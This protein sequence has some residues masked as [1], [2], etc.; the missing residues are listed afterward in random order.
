M[1]ACERFE[2]LA[3]ESRQ[4]KDRT[5]RWRQIV[6]AFLECYPTIANEIRENPDR[7]KDRADWVV[8]TA[9]GYGFE[10]TDAQFAPLVSE[11]AKQMRALGKENPSSE[12]SKEEVQTKAD[13]VMMFNGQFVHDAQ[14]LRI[15]GAGIDFVF[16]RTYKNQVPYNGPLG[17]NWD[18]N[19]NLWLRVSNQT[20][21]RSTGDLREEAYVRHPKFDQGGFD[22]WVPPDGQHA[23]IIE[24]GDSFIW[25]TPSGDRHFYEPDPARSSFLHRISLIEDKH[26]NFLD[27]SY[28]DDKLHQVAINHVDR[29]V[30]FR[31]DEQN[32]INLIIDYTGRQWCYFYDFFEDLI[33]VTTPGT[34]RYSE[35]V[36]VCYEYSS[37]QFAGELQHN[38]TH[39]ID[40][41]GQ[42]HLE[43][44]YGTEP[45]R[46]RFNRVISQRQGGGEFLFEYEDIIQEFEIDYSEAER[47]AHQTIMVERSGHP[48]CHVYNKF[49]NLLSKEEYIRQDG[50]LRTLVW[51]YRHNRDGK[52]IATLSPEG[53]I[54]QHLYGREYF[55]RSNGITDEDEVSTHDALTLEGRQGFGQLLAT[56]RRGRYYGLAELNLA[57]DVWGDIFPDI[58]GGFESDDTVIKFTYKLTYGQLLTVSNPRFTKSADP[59][60]Q[61]ELAG[62]HPRY[63]ES[64]TQYKYTG[65]V[66]DPSRL[67]AEIQRP[68]P[69]LPDGTLADSVIEK[70]D[71]YDDRGRLLRYFDSAGVLTEHTYF[72]SGDGRRE[73]YLRRTVL[74]AG[75]L[76]NTTEY[77]VDELG[78]VMAVHLPRSVGAPPGH[79]VTRTEYNEIDQV[80]RMTASPPFNFETRRFYDKNG[81]LEREER[82]A[83][84]DTGADIPGAP[85]VQTFEYDEELNLVRETIGG[86]DLSDHLVT[87]HCYDS[88]GQRVL[89]VLP[90]GNRIGFS[91]DERLLPVAQTVAVGTADAATRHV[92][93]DGD[94][95]VRRTR[96]ARNDLTTLTLDPFG[97]VT[98]QED[99]L[100][101]LVRRTYD[102]ASN[103]T[104][105]RI[106]ERQENGTFVLVARSEFEYDELG[107][108]IRAGVNRFEDALL[109]TNLDSD[110]L[111]SPGLGELLVTQTF[112]DAKGRVIRTVDPLGRERLF[113]YDALDRVTA[114][115]DA[116]GNRIENQYDAHGNLVRQDFRDVVRNPETGGIVSERIFSSSSTYDELDR[117]VTDTNTLGNVIHYT[118]DSRNNLVCRVDPLGNVVRTQFDIYGRLVT[119][120]SDQTD[121]GLEEG[122]PLAS[123]FTRYKYDANG[124]L[125]GITD[126]L[127]RRIRQIYDALD[128]RRAVIFP[129]GSRVAFDYDPD[130]NL[131]M[132][133][134]NNG[135]RRHYTVDALGRTTRV[136]VDDVQLDAAI[137]AE[138]ANF[139]A[140]GYDAL[141]RRVHEENNYAQIDIRFNSLG[142]PLQETLTF[143]TSDAHLDDPRIITRAFNNAGAL[144]ELTYPNG[145]RLRFHRDDLDR[146][147]RVE[148]MVKGMD[149][150]GNTATSDVHDIAV[151]EYA[152]R[153]RSRCAF[154]NGGAV[155][156]RHDG[157]G[158]IIEIAHTSSDTLLLTIQYLFDAVGNPRF[159]NEIRP[160]ERAGEA[161]KYDSFYRLVRVE[162]RNDLPEFDAD[163]FAPAS[164]VSHPIPDRQTDINALIGPLALIPGTETLVYDLV[165]NRK[166]EQLPGGG[167][168]TYAINDQDQYTERNE[169]SFTYDRNGNLI[170]DAVRKYRYDSLNRL[171]RVE[172]GG[173]IV[174]FFHDSNGRRILEL[175]NGLATH[176]IYD[177]ENLLAEYRNGVPFAQYVHDDDVDRPLQIAAKAGDPSGD[178]NEHWYHTDLVG[179][180]RLL[181]NRTGA[182]AATYRYD[183]F[184]N[185]I[186]APTEGPYNPMRYTA[187][188]F[189]EDLSTYDY[190]ARQYNPQLGRFHQRDSVGMTDGTNLY[191]YTTNN[192]MAFSDPLGLNR[193]DLE[194]GG[195]QGCEERKPEEEKKERRLEDFTVLTPQEL[196]ALYDN[197]NDFNKQI[198]DI[199]EWKRGLNSV[200][201]EV[202]KS[203]KE[204]EKIL[205]RLENPV[206]P[207]WDSL[208]NFSSGIGGVAGCYF[209]GPY[210]C[211]VSLGVAA[212]SIYY[213]EEGAAAGVVIDCPGGV[214]PCVV[215]VVTGGVSVVFAQQ[216]RITE[217]TKRSKADVAKFLITQ[218]KQ[219]QKQSNQK[220]K[221]LD[222][223]LDELQRAKSEIEKSINAH[224][225]FER[226]KK[227]KESPDWPW[228]WPKKSGT[229]TWL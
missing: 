197:L 60:Q 164:V 133:Q 166:L 202:R 7:A 91:Y 49:G 32:R 169:T 194:T 189:D 117:L 127:G 204:A 101:N 78:R 184:G 195:C 175:R 211:L 156:Y 115:T 157:A 42:M 26:G 18:H 62:E 187:R 185:P 72:R 8:R 207:N 191:S 19:Y 2:K 80:I 95:H 81:K 106:F 110:F 125:I 192:P 13:P 40:P 163:E 176:L 51:R 84:D 199:N 104:V 222:T 161:F 174:R 145:R 142:W 3:R 198:A 99:A 89:T 131:I 223:Q 219:I 193:K 64:L 215:S 208:G 152:G 5:E 132:T 213:P 138:G 77:E 41:A 59:A 102:K 107:R 116:L 96:S 226:L 15:S 75:G 122:N 79:F 34:N 105:E 148:N 179:S 113:E 28:Q 150:P 68:T 30:E 16:T 196:T 160:S 136:D 58:F 220:R 139:E 74:D 33:A 22:Y 188:R 47:P 126:A 111:D 181:T 21:F 153:Q 217:R 118:Y 66:D 149:Y 9:N 87:K 171:V 12:S 48:I 205:F 82:D 218:A 86:A 39:I 225:D 137:V 45:G 55:N 190:R 121:T 54:T 130:G 52:L 1:G 38:L 92:E 67:L 180:V 203:Q 73:G 69:T 44:E 210:G 63:E 11:T 182:E 178:G 37:A 61:T 14:D 143:T 151:F 172:S 109:A 128:R 57:R 76:A 98:A 165:G 119:E 20:I 167:T 201:A 229:G 129:D 53:V 212:Y 4:A 35:G 23:V 146:L 224:K 227:I 135:L 158:R 173:N 65:P 141:G 31:Y 200:N 209:T 71:A 134:D 112:Y 216:S 140:Y 50:L 214:A 168:V 24:H 83:K 123:A 228:A 85:E 154:G 147:V 162:N 103:L 36:A 100:A 27:F 56:V 170:N 120:I 159:R 206:W 93:Y 108:T 155:S 25:R 94:G 17:F 6:N 88:T 29:V 177:G 43:N 183:P 124:N 90:A 97:R 114:K 186:I 70:F 144:T 10:V 46:L 221:T